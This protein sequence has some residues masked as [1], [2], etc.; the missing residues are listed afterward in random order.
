MTSNQF[1]K[2]SRSLPRVDYKE[3][4]D[5]CSPKDEENQSETNTNDDTMS[6]YS[7]PP[8]IEAVGEF[9]VAEI[10]A[11][12]QDEHGRG[13]MFEVRWVDFVE[14][15]WQPAFELL[16]V[17]HLVRKFYEREALAMNTQLDDPD[18]AMP[19]MFSSADADKTN[20]SEFLLGAGVVQ[21]PADDPQSNPD[22]GNEGDGKEI[23]GTLYEDIEEISVL[24]DWSRYEARDL[25]KVEMMPWDGT[26]AATFAQLLLKKTATRSIGDETKR[27][28]LRSLHDIGNSKIVE[29]VA[30]TT[31]TPAVKAL[32]ISVWLIVCLKVHNERPPTEHQPAH[33]QCA[34]LHHSAVQIAVR[35]AA[36]YEDSENSEDYIIDLIRYWSNRLGDI[37]S[38]HGSWDDVHWWQTIS[39]NISL[40]PLH[41]DPIADEFLDSLNQEGYSGLLRVVLETEMTGGKSP[42]RIIW[43]KHNLW[44]RTEALKMF[45][46]IPL[47][48]LEA[49]I[50]GTLPSLSERE[51]SPVQ[52]EMTMIKDR[53]DTAPGTYGNFFTDRSGMALSPLVLGPIVED[54]RRYIKPKPTMEDHEWAIEVDNVLCPKKGW[55]KALIRKGFRRY[56]DWR[57]KDKKRP[58]QKPEKNRCRRGIIA[59]FT[60]ELLGSCEEAAR[61]HR[62][63][64]PM[65]RALTNIGFSVKPHNRLFRHHAKHFQSNYIMN[66][67]HALLM[68]RYGNLFRLQQMTLYTCW[69]PS[70]CWLSEILLTRLIQGY[71]KSGRGFSHYQAGLS[72]YG[73]Y[74]K[75]SVETWD[76]I[77]LNSHVHD[78]V[79]DAMHDERSHI[80]KAVESADHNL[81]RLENFKKLQDF[82]AL[83]K[84]WAEVRMKSLDKAS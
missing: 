6:E 38:V 14:T 2:R 66:L 3:F 40:F 10:V 70:Q 78:L 68:C 5:H 83:M 12:G 82:T 64:S 8:A 26:G 52:V 61:S 65:P 17:K 4:F 25:L 72:N 59:S 11:A 1:T 44:V 63:Y 77:T 53:G 9:E 36:Q 51:G 20:Q 37:R 73:A 24:Y 79:K 47:N 35:L 13:L 32:Y 56:T 48:V 30:G 60:Q 43:E 33:V 29:E 28:F 75:L 76:E 23:E 31:V 67:F 50:Q 58:D 55:T 84:D 19:E 81:V 34:V 80:A 21:A 27:G 42:L 49:F 74:R 39:Q 7:E 15:T 16:S 71:V 69:R 46:S 57:P 18:F 41:P 54:M 22:D 45:C 62:M